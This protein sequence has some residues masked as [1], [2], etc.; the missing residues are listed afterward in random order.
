MLHVTCY[1]LHV[2]CIMQ[3]GQQT[4]QVLPQC[5]APAGAR[6]G[7][8]G[9]QEAEEVSMMALCFRDNLEQFRDTTRV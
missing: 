4:D 6:A 5:A 9:E 2:T 8:K 3:V 1:M 7:H